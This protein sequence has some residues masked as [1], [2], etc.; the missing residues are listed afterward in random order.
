[1]WYRNRNQNN[2]WNSSTDCLHRISFFPSKADVVTLNFRVRI[3]WVSPFG[4]Q[5]SEHMVGDKI[6]VLPGVLLFSS[7]LPLQELGGEFFVP[8]SAPSTSP[9]FL[10][11]ATFVIKPHSICSPRLLKDCPRYGSWILPSGPL[12]LYPACFV[13]L[14]SALSRAPGRQPYSHLHSG[15]SQ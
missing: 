8:T 2:S 13:C 6:P 1:M 10:P 12:A 4:L 3:C 14:P 15:T 9:A 7:S 5:E 11:A